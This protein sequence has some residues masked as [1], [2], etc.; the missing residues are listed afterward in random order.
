M[1]QKESRALIALASWDPKPV[2]CKLAI[3]WKGLRINLAKAILQA[4]QAKDFQPEM[5]FRPTDGI[6]PESGKGWLLV[7]SEK[8]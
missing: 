5:A 3:D 6:P 1:Y 2:T 4:H 8:P 7:L